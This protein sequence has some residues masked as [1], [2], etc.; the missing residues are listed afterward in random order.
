M[1]DLVGDKVFS[2]G[3]AYWRDGVVELLAVGPKRVLAQV[4]GP[5]D[6]RVELTGR[7]ES[8]DGTCSCPA[9]GDWGYCKHWVA[10][11]L[12]ANAAGSDAEAKSLDAFAE[13]RRYLN[14]K[15]VSA[16]VETIMDCVERDPILFRRLA[17]ASI[18]THEDGA[19]L[20]A[21]LGKMIDG[22][23][24]T[25][26]FVDYS[27]AAC[28]ARGVDE[29]LDVIAELST[30][31]AGI[32]LGL[33]MRT[34]DRIESAI[35][36]IDDSDGHCGALLDRA[37][38][39]HRTAAQTARPAPLSLAR[40]LFAREMKD[41]YDIFGGAAG[42]YGDI[43]GD[44][45]LAEYHRLATEAWEKLPASS[46]K[47][48]TGMGR[49]ENHF[50]LRELLDFF[51]ERDG[52]VEA[53][54]ALRAKHLDSQGSYLKIAQFCLSQDRA[55]EALRWVEDGLWMFEDDLPDERL[56]ALAVDL[57]SK[58]G[59]DG[60][61]EAHLWRAFEKA[62]S[63]ELYQ[64]LCKAAGAAARDK[65]VKRLQSRL[66]GAKSSAWHFPADL[67]ITILMEEK[68]FERAWL[69]VRDH[70][71]SEGLKQKLAR[72]SEAT[73]PREALMVYAASVD[74]MAQLGGDGAYAEAAALIGRMAGLHGA[75]AHAAYLADVKV[76]FGRKRNFMKLLA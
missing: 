70:G 75:S 52:D 64:R 55:K 21:R 14:G 56:I 47:N 26:G 22:A 12:A 58:A 54:I 74:Q 9:F 16:L 3:E 71:A 11:A 10:T 37:C 73:H 6:Y 42:R 66:T 18:V 5:Q 59:R 17:A 53:R 49:P 76:R 50:R 4:A 44:E 27:E 20:E 67:L 68:Q 24:A 62:P 33:A 8:A 32:A 48:R 41:N 57:L 35:D 19:T 7:G 43:L 25:N 29:V 65:A 51:A 46:G 15:D 2:R 30:K 13:I 39:L 45:G 72:A 36:D 34:I 31:Q 40:D 63:L 28:W 23:T 1:R 38:E 61:A 69:N 60:D